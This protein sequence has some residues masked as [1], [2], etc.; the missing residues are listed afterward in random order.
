MHLKSC[1]NQGS[2]STGWLAAVVLVCAGELHGQSTMVRAVSS[3]LVSTNGQLELMDDQRVSIRQADG[4]TSMLNPSDI[5]FIEFTGTL[6]SNV[7]D[8]KV[9][10][11]YPDGR[12]EVFAR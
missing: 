6:E 12:T 3:D 10:K 4:S 2:R 9:R 8:G 11:T 1:F 5:A 7:P